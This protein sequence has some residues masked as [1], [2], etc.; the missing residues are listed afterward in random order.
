MPR[1]AVVGIGYPAGGVKLSPVLP[2]DIP[3]AVFVAVHT[4][5]L[6]TNPLTSI[7]TRPDVYFKNGGK[8]VCGYSC[9]RDYSLTI[10]HFEEKA[11]K[12]PKRKLSSPKSDAVK[13]TIKK[14]AIR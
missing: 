10:Q 12:Q 1:C 4:I 6:N 3:A 7:L 8:I 9:K 2:T 11:R 5:S 13:K 14:E